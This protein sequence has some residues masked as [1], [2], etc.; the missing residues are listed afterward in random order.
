MKTIQP[1][2]DPSKSVETRVM[3]LLLR[4]TLTEKCAQLV[5]PFGLEHP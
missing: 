2:Q 5:G 3:D 1:Y 4:M